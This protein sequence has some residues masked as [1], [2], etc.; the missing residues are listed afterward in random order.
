[1]GWGR[2]LGEAKRG[3]RGRHDQVIL[4]ARIRFSKN[5]GKF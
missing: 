4:Y 1:M 2:V 5:K 3:R